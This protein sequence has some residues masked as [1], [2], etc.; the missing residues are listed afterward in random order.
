MCS[1]DLEALD[2]RLRVQA[3]PGIAPA[4]WMSIGA[5]VEAGTEPLELELRAV[6]GVRFEI[7]WRKKPEGDRDLL[8][9]APDGEPC[10]R[11]YAYG[12]GSDE[13]RLA[14]GEY[15]V[16]AWQGAQRLETQTISVRPETKRVEL[17]L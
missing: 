8:F 9:R 13:I 12:E 10:L 3:R 11:W 1:S 16:E 2:S 6:R 17:S 7:A 14:P 15:S 4:E 5:I